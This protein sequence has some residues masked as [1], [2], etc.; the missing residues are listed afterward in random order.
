MDLNVEREARMDPPIQVEYNRSGGA[1]IRIFI[2]VVAN[3]CFLI[4]LSRR[5]PNPC[6]ERVRERNAYK[7]E[8]PKE[9]AAR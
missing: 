5:S 2:P 1:A 9:Y 8:L 4:S 3:E 7:Y 6:A